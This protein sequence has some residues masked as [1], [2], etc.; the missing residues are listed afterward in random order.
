[1]LTF[2]CDIATS[3]QPHLN[4]GEQ[5]GAGRTSPKSLPALVIYQ[6]GKRL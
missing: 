3:L 1:M 4:F 6:G 5:S 2:V